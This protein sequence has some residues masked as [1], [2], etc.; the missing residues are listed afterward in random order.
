MSDEEEDYMSSKFLEEAASF[1]NQMKN[2]ESVMETAENQS[3]IH[4][5][6]EVVLSS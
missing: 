6:S 4:S 3:I 5:T 1:E 2:K